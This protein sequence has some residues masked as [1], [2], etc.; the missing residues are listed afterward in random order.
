MEIKLTYREAK[1]LLEKQIQNVTDSE[2]KAALQTA[3]IALGS[4]GQITT[5][6]DIAIEQLQ[7]M[8]HEFG[9]K[10]EDSRLVPRKPEH[11]GC[12]DADGVRHEWVGVDGRPYELCP[13][14]EKNLCCE[15]PFDTKPKFCN[16][17]GQA[18]DW[19]RWKPY[20]TPSK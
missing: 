5:E 13:N 1:R 6:R 9:E 14:C 12:T 20:E 3:I 11:A 7:I 15:G 8:G 2:T 19:T 18:L 17:C 16:H 10:T 4:I